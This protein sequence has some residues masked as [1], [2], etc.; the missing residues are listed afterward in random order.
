MEE[1][2]RTLSQLI[3][4]GVGGQAIRTTSEH[5][6]YVRGKGWTAC[7]NLQ[8]GDL[9]RSHDG[10]W[11]TVE[12]LNYTNEYHVVYNLRIAEYHTYFVGSRNW[13][14]SVWA[15]NSYNV[16]KGLEQAHPNLP[17][18]TSGPTSGLF[19]GDL[20]LT[21]GKTGGRALEVFASKMA[22]LSDDALKALTHV[23]GYAAAEMV[24]NGLK[25]GTLFINYATGPCRFCRAGI[26]ELLQAGQKLWVVFPKGVGF[27][28]NAGWTLFLL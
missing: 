19:N 21:S 18:R 9:L 12:T 6:F 8:E 5:P 15:H 1:A 3:H 22:S 7:K 13:K 14:F 4:V 28:T 20:L 25:E 2:F 23:E 10:K 26:A 11:V 24:M 27:F 16:P 17:V